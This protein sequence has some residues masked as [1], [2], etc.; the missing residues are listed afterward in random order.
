MK[1]FFDSLKFIVI[2]WSGIVIAQIFA[3]YYNLFFYYWWIDIP[4]HFAGGVWVFVFARYVYKKFGID[5]SGKHIKVLKFLAFI[6]L[7]ALVGILW[8]FFEFVMDRYVAFS[9]LSFMFNGFTHFKGMYEDTLKDL[10]MDILGGAVAF[11]VYFK[12]GKA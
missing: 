12:N 11:L 7:V 8:E 4:F 2:F 3:L 10:L 6:S 9:G 1:P 5:I